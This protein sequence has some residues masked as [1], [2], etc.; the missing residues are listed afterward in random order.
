ML[1]DKAGFSGLLSDLQANILQHHLRM[2]TRCFFLHVRADKSGHDNTNSA[3]E[4]IQSIAGELMTA[5]EQMK[6]MRDNKINGITGNR[7]PVMCLYLTWKGYIR[8][9][10]EYFTPFDDRGSFEKGLKNR[11]PFL[12]EKDTEFRFDDGRE[13]HAM[14]LVATD[15]DIALDIPDFKKP[16]AVWADVVEQEGRLDRNENKVVTDRFGFRDGIRQPRYFPDLQRKEEKKGV[17]HDENE[18][19]SLRVVL[20]K[21][22]GGEHKYSAGSFMAYLKIEQN[23][24]AFLAMQHTIAAHAAIYAMEA[25]VARQKIKSAVD[26]KEVEKLIKLDAPGKSRISRSISRIE[27]LT[28]RRQEKMTEEAKIVATEKNIAGIIVENEIGKL[29][30]IRPDKK[31]GLLKEMFGIIQKISNN[32]DAEQDIQS[33]INDFNNKIE[34]LKSEAEIALLNTRV[35][36]SMIDSIGEKVP[37]LTKVERETLHET[38]DNIFSL[39]PIEKRNLIKRLSTERLPLLTSKEVRDIIEEKIRLGE[40]YIMGRFKDG[41][42]VTTHAAP[43]NFD[44]ALKE[45]PPYSK[46]M[47]SNGANSVDDLKG[48]RCPYAAHARK[49]NPRDGN[50]S[51]LIARRGVSYEEKPATRD[52]TGQGMLFMSYQANLP[53]QF[54]YILKRWINNMHYDKQATGVDILAGSGINR[55]ISHW[56]FPIHWNGENPEEK[57][58]LTAKELKPCIRYLEGEYFFAPSISFLQNIGRRSTIKPEASTRKTTKAPA[59]FQTKHVF[60]GYPIKPIRL[61]RGTIQIKAD[62]P[63]KK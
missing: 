18:L 8:L 45:D 9:G 49:A 51:R 10:L 32:K 23:P 13:L 62:E 60:D 29:I 42:T 41:T 50:Q 16:D 56:Y 34:F 28:N 58:L 43:G 40:A 54:E 53:E 38:L 33:M 22:R 2:K 48:M 15:N 25:L 26:I 52:A 39:D 24:K 4:W 20:T 7:K 37:R 1:H 30:S 19:A 14:L 27:S 47:I 36:E 55:E 12:F 3:L 5:E 57:F 61:L 44:S 59:V 11:V 21:D 63:V 35:I 6:D 31:E 17:V 46:K